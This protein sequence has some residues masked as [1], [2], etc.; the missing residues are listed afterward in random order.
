MIGLILIGRLQKRLDGSG[1]R[2]SVQLA[3]EWECAIEIEWWSK[4]WSA[5]RQGESSG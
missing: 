4:D 5:P 2:G 3:R 1:A